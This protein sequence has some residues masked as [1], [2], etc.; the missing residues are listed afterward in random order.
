MIEPVSTIIRNKIGHNSLTIGILGDISLHNI[1]PST[2]IFQPLIPIIKDTD[3]VIANV[4]TVISDK[5]LT[6]S[7]KNGIFLKSPKSS[8]KILKVIGVDIALLANNHIDDY[9]QIGVFDTISNLEEEN[10]SVFGVKERE[11]LLIEQNNISFEIVGF[12]TPYE[13][14]EY[15]LPY[16]TKNI[17]ELLPL[18]RNYPTAHLLYFLHGFDELYS[19]PFPWRVNLL[20]R[21]C[22]QYKPSALICGHQHIYQGFIH[23][24]NTPICLS[25]GNGFM[26]IE[27]HKMNPDAKIGCYTVMHFDNVG[28]FQIDGYLYEITKK[29]IKKT[30]I[31]QYDR[32]KFNIDHIDEMW[33]KECFEKLD[34]HK[35]KRNVFINLLYDFYR[36]I[37]LYKSF[38]DIYYSMFKC[39]LKEK[40]NIN[41]IHLSKKHKS[42]RIA[43]RVNG[44]LKEKAE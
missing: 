12:V 31:N 2:S 22:N 35:Y 16:H 3:I 15:L 42:N 23:H 24:N 41:F 1:I 25:Y 8:A 5:A 40:W 14:D 18:K 44:M 7:K 32:V 10:I 13:S 26:N 38:E 11:S 39:Y 43:E 28:C 21:M 19:V 29:E 6:A 9:G 33:K 17:N 27:Y 30:N 20:K 34:T 37:K 4:E 36:Y